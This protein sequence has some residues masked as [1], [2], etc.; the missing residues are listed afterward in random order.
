MYYIYIRTYIHTYICIYIY[1]HYIYLL[2]MY[3]MTYH[4]C[5]ATNVI[6]CRVYISHCLLHPASEIERGSFCHLRRR[7]LRLSRAPARTEHGRAGR[8]R[9]YMEQTYLDIRV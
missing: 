6:C 1:I 4:V 9:I 7:V 8:A 2:H 5:D 3:Q